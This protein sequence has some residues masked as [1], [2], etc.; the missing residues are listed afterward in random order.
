MNG[1]ETT[2]AVDD[3]STLLEAACCHGG[4]ES[5]VCLLQVCMISLASAQIFF[6]TRAGRQKR[7]GQSDRA[8]SLRKDSV[9]LPAYADVIDQ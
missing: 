7:K 5:R 3:I 4:S 1:A 9:W 2:V 8:A 6:I